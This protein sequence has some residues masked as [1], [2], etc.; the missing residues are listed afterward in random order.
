MATGRAT[1]EAATATDHESSAA[2]ADPVSPPRALEPEPWIPPLRYRAHSMVRWFAPTEIVRGAYGEFFGRLFGSYADSR[3]TQAALREP[4]VHH[5]Q[6]PIPGGRLGSIDPDNFLIFC[7]DQLPYQTASDRT[8]DLTVDYVADVGDGFSPTFA[9]ARQMAEPTTAVGVDGETALVL[10]KGDLI[11]M[12]GDEVYP[13][14]GA[15]HY[16]D[17]TIGPYRTAYPPE[18]ATGPDG[19]DRRVPLFAI[20]GNHDWYDGLAAFLER[21]TVFQTG[22]DTSRRRGWS[23]HQTRSYFAI[24]LNDRW[25]LW[26]IDIALNADI[27]TP[28]MQYFRQVAAMMPSDARIVLCTGKPA[29]FRRG[30]RGWFE[31]RLQA[32][33]ER[34]GRFE[35]EASDEWNRLT[36]FLEE[37]LGAAAPDAVRLVMT[38]DKHFYARHEP[39][40]DTA[41][42]T[43]VVAGGG[44]GLSRVHA[45][46]SPQAGASLALLVGREHRLRGDPGMA[47]TAD[48]TPDGSDGTVAYPVG[49]PGVGDGL[50]G[51]LHPVRSG[52]EGGSQGGVR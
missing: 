41:K 9:V 11:I 27:D 14:A 8:G 50:R 22:D 51:H 4:V 24:Q 46:G 35:P 29:W 42:P 32:M 19:S 21:F 49:Q 25:W 16:R 3:E 45:G 10:P 12:G 2:N 47:R 40:A 17:R 39:T 38:G 48:L 5:A 7:N 26:G 28:Q 44:G 13:A 43:V 36:Y 31:R 1:P 37:T 18:S 20:P 15:E 6:G 34:F 52:G 33:R 30:E 23:L